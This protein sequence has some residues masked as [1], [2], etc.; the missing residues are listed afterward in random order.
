MDKIDNK[1]IIAEIKAN[2]AVLIDVREKGEF[3]DFS[4]DEAI[5]IPMSQY[6]LETFIEHAD[7]SIYLICYS[8]NRS[9]RVAKRLWKEGKIKVGLAKEQMSVHDPKNSVGGW[10]IDRQFRMTLG[11]LL[12]IAI[13]GNQFLSVYFLVIPI[14]LATGLI[15]TSILNKCYMRM[16]IAALPWNKGRS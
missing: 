15:V 7:K 5:N 11:I 4:I 6:Q 14:I 12:A 1:Q 9:G 3:K 10:T 16:G 2:K 13:L 8:G